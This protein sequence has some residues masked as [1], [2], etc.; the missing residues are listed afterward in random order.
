MGKASRNARVPIEN[1]FDAPHW[2]RA[3]SNRLELPMFDGSP[4]A[5]TEW[6][7]TLERV[8]R[9][10][11]VSDARKVKLVSKC[12]NGRVFDQWN[13]LQVTRQRKGKGKI[14]HWDTMKKKLNEKYFPLTCASPLL[15]TKQQNTIVSS[16]KQQASSCLGSGKLFP[17]VTAHKHKL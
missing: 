11:Y 15:V 5:F 1:S 14:R 4:N 6:L 13:D 3:N 2:C 12:F 16:P 7:D 10:H 17:A 9:C 8:F